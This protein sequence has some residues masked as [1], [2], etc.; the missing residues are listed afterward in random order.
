MKVKVDIS[1]RYQPEM[2]LVGLLHQQVGPDY[3]AKVVIPEVEQALRTAM[4]GL[5]MREV[6]G[7]Q[8]A[9]VQQVVN[10]SSDRISQKYI[11]LDEIVLREITLP[12]KVRAE[13]DDKMVQKEIAESYEFRL[14]IAHQE[15]DRRKIEADGLKQYQDIL[16]SSLTP[17][18]LKWHGIEATRELAKSPNSKT[19]IIGSKSDGLPM[20]LGDG[21]TTGAGPK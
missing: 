2:E 4:S 9:I 6:Y 14:Q 12:D 13:I 18:V 19:I 16:A 1:I 7:S 3:A 5:P 21:A 10:D 20:I 8:R 17:N 11:R 15:A